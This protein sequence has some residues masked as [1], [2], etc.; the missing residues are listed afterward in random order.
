MNKIK[1]INW[2]LEKHKYINEYRQYAKFIISCIEDS[3]FNQAD[4]TDIMADEIIEMLEPQSFNDFVKK[5]ILQIV[6]IDELFY[7]K[8]QKEINCFIYSV[9]K[10]IYKNYKNNDIT[11]FRKTFN[12][13]NNYENN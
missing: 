3:Q 7:N 5:I 11:N 1:E 2:N 12:L 13:I 9:T 10:Q 6:N 8:K 4:I